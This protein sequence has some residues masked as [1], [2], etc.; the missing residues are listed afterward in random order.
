MRRFG[1][2]R[3][4]SGV[5][6]VM[7]TCWLDRTGIHNRICLKKSNQIIIEPPHDKTS[8]VACAPSEDS[9]QPGHL[10]G[11]IRGFALRSMGS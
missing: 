3:M 8:K 1:T 5:M 11:L 6:V 4:T 10:H 9:D 7:V 2:M